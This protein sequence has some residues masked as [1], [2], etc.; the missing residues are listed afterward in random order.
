MARRYFTLFES[1][2][3]MLGDADSDEALSSVLYHKAKYHLRI[4]LSL[5]ASTWKEQHVKTH[6]DLGVTRELY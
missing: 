4:V 1:S 3:D 6:L 5:D 2:P